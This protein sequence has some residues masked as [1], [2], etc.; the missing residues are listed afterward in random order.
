METYF[1]FIYEKKKPKQQ[2]PLPLYVEEAVYIEL[3]KDVEDDQQED[4]IILD[5]L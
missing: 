2:E 5:I 3:P 1:T 4:Y